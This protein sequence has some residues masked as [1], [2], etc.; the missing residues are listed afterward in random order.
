[1]DLLH[2]RRDDDK[3]QADRVPGALLALPRHHVPDLEVALPGAAKN[4]EALKRQASRSRERPRPAGR[5]GAS[6]SAH[7]HD[8]MPVIIPPIACDRR[9]TNIECGFCSL[10]PVA[11]A[12]FWRP[13][14][15][16]DQAGWNS[17]SSPSGPY[18]TGVPYLASLNEAQRCAVEHGVVST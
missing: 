6:R 14:T 3:P 18:M 4:L 2:V 7:I 5:R 12:V 9:L 11:A 10:R 8:R 15:N 16:H 13:R 17:K 1:M